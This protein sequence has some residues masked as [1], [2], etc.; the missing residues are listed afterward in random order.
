MLSI[1][2]LPAYS[3]SSL[4][5]EINAR[6]KELDL[7]REGPMGTLGYMIELAPTFIS[8]GEDAYRFVY[9][10][11]CMPDLTTCTNLEVWTTHG[12]KVYKFHH[13]F[14]GFLDPIIEAMINS[15]K[16]ME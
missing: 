7:Y 16:I 5:D 6:I 8:N 12:D 1:H 11:V 3:S 4:V 15:L 14:W 13:T 10:D 2:K 9:V